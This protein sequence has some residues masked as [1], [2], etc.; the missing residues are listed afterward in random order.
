VTKYNYNLDVFYR[1]NALSYYLLGVFM[2]DGNINVRPNRI[3]PSLKSK[4]LDWLTLIRDQICPDLKILKEKNTNCYALQIY[5][6]QLGRW[7]ISRGCTANKSLSLRMPNVPEEYFFDF[8]R[9]CLDGDGTVAMYSKNT[10]TIRLHSSSKQFIYAIN[11]KLLN[12]GISSRIVCIPPYTHK[13]TIQGRIIEYK[14]PYYKLLLTGKQCIKLANLAYYPNNALSMPRKQK[15]AN[16]L[17]GEQ[18]RL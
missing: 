15:V 8:L 14:N 5:S 7:L 12:F 3:L 9:G 6:T 4:D 11:E 2:T 18:A 16:I 1:E 17:I 10:R 13:S